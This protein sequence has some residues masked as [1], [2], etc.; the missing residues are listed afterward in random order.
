MRAVA[1]EVVADGTA[2]GEDEQ[3]QAPCTSAP[4]ISATLGVAKGRR[5]RT[6]RPVGQAV[7]TFNGDG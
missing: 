2:V 6:R 5:R 4:A 3:G 7:S 1:R